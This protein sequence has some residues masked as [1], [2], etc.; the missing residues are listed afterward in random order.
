MKRNRASKLATMDEALLSFVRQARNHN[1]SLTRD[2][3]KAKEFA[4][5]WVMNHLEIDSQM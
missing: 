2:N 5:K 4:E 3:T 1:L